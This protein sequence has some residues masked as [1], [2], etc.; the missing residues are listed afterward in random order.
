MN[1]TLIIIA[2]A[3][4]ASLFIIFCCSILV[5]VMRLNR[6]VKSQLKTIDKLL[7]S[8]PASRE[9]DTPQEPS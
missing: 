9:R 3:V 1:S 4:G 6:V 8:P 5:V 2:L 7:N